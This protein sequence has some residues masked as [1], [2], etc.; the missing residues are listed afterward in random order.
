MVEVEAIWT[1]S[2]QAES[3]LYPCADN[4][5]PAFETATWWSSANNRAAQ[6]WA[7]WSASLLE[8]ANDF[9]HHLRHLHHP[10][11]PPDWRVFASAV[12]VPR[13]V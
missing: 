13:A 4:I 10:S 11:Q 3:N 8:L 5:D 1:V 12:P 9:H 6:W 7:D 2:T